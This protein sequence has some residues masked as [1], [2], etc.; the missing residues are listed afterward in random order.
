MAKANGPH[1][2]TMTDVAEHPGR[3]PMSLV[4]A[5]VEM[6]AV[7]TVLDPFC[8]SGTVCMAAAER[9]IGFVGLDINHAFVELAT[10]NVE[11]AVH[12]VS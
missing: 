9:G 4:R 5:I 12:A 7:P 3:K 1:T 6:F 2:I 8:G 11:E 10:K